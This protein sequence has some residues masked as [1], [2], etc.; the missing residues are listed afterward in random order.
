MSIFCNTYRMLRRSKE[1]PEKNWKGLEEGHSNHNQAGQH[2]WSLILSFYILNLWLNY[3]GMPMFEDILFLFK[4]ICCVANGSPSS[5]HK[6]RYWLWWYWQGAQSMIRSSHPSKTRT[7]QL[8]LCTWRHS[9]LS[10]SNPSTTAPSIH[11]VA[12]LS[13]QKL[14]CCKHHRQWRLAKTVHATLQSR[15][16]FQLYVCIWHLVPLP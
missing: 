9:H 15:S 5:R 6:H 13:C 8:T 11:K 3:W 1:I 2:P 16:I 7:Q 14:L 4:H 10:V 12:I